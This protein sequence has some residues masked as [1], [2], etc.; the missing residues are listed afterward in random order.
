M[1]EKGGDL[2]KYYPLRDDAWKEYEVWKAKQD[3]KA[4]PKQKAKAKKK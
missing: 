3:K 4:K 1:L 2:R